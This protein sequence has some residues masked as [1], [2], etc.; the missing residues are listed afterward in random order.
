MGEVFCLFFERHQLAFCKKG[1]S[2]TG[3]DVER[4]Q[5]SVPKSRWCLYVGFGCLLS[6]QSTVQVPV[7]RREGVCTVRFLS[8]N[9]YTTRF[10][11]SKEEQNCWEV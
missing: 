5:S 6:S 10:L 2:L 4:C 8:W 9:N 3:V 7:G 11:C 1:L